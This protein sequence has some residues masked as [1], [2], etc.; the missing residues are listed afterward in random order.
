MSVLQHKQQCTKVWLSG[1]MIITIH[2]N[3]PA[4]VHDTMLMTSTKTWYL[5]WKWVKMES[6]TLLKRINLVDLV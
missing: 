2:Q 5:Q 1:F 3:V 6:C 4:V